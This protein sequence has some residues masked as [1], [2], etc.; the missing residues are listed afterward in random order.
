V[1]SIFLAREAG[2]RVWATDLWVSADDSWTRIVEAGQQDL[3]CPIRAEAHAL[4]FAAG[5]FEAIL[6]VDSYQYYGTDDTYLGYITRFLEPGGRLGLVMPAL[7]QEIDTEP[8]EHLTRVRDHGSAFW[9]PTECWCFHTLDWWRRHLEHTGL[10][11]I[12]HAEVVA[13]GWRLW[14]DWELVRNGGGLT[15]F[16]SEAETL[17]A[18][19]GRYIGFVRIIA[20]KRPGLSSRPFDHPLLI[21]L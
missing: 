6:S 1:T 5:F 17:E 13:D 20:R 18:D 7:M 21:R 16:P 9:D 15:G 19:Q 12:E 10:V 8:P 2:H 14:R 3:V 4:P 11:E